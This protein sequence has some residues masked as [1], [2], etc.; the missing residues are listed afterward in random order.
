HTIL[1]GLHEDHINMSKIAALVAAELAVIEDGTHPDY[2][3]LEN[4]MSYV[5]AYP[6]TYHHP[7]EDIVFARLRHVAPE[8]GRDI[9]VLLA[10]HEELVAYGREFLETI[11]AIEEEAVVTRADFLAKGRGYLDLLTS[12]MNREEAGLF[13]LAAERLDA[14]DWEEISTRVEAIEDPLFGPALNAD[15]RRLWQRITAHHPIR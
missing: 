15:Y 6:D 5:T 12:H 1:Q 7:T 4:I 11:R 14:S 10:E 2:E 8:A 9:D 3:L 13:R